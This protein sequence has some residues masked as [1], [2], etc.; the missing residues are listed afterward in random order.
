MRPAL[1]F[2]VDGVLVDVTRS[3]RAAIAAT[4]RAFTGEEPSGPEMQRYKNL[5]GYNNDWLLSQRLCADRGVEV[6]YETVV[7][8]FNEV[9]FGRAG[10]GLIAQEVWL[11]REGLLA[12]LAAR[13][14]LALFT[15]RSRAE[16]AVTLRREGCAGVFDPIVTSDDVERGKPAPD[17]LEAIAETCG[18]RAALFLGDTVDDARS[19]QVAGVP[20]LGVLAGLRERPADRARLLDEGALAVIE[21]VNEVLEFVR[22]LER[23]G[24]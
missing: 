1:V 3:Y 4:V 24:R 8:H 5:G 22:R 16:L 6:A 13:Y 17:G 14:R 9:F 12:S 20:F 23:S 11:P 15:G 10:E 18:G 19:A 2:D 7:E 21:D